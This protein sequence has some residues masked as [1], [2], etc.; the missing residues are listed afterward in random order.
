VPKPYSVAS[1]RT[2]FAV[3]TSRLLSEVAFY[4]AGEKK[5]WY[6]MDYDATETV[7]SH[8]MRVTEMTSE[9]SL[10]STQ[11]EY[12]S[13]RFSHLLTKITLPEGAIADLSYD[14]SALQKK[15]DGTPA[16]PKLPMNL[17][18]LTGIKVTE[19]VT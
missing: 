11:F 2:N 12:G 1:Y 19:P 8:L 4:A 9:A 18:I 6:K 7:N 16:N 13:G 15:P 3:Q 5:R 14:I 17:M 10:P